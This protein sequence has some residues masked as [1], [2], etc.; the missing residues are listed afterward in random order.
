MLCCESVKTCLHT[1]FLLCHMYVPAWFLTVLPVFVWI[2]CSLQRVFNHRAVLTLVWLLNHLSPLTAPVALPYQPAFPSRGFVTAVKPCI[3]VLTHDVLPCPSP[4]PPPF[5]PFFCWKCT[6]PPLLLSSTGPLC[7]HNDV[8]ISIWC[9]GA[10]NGLFYLSLSST[11]GAGHWS[12]ASR[13]MAAQQAAFYSHD[14]ACGTEERR[15]EG[16]TLTAKDHKWHFVFMVMRKK[17][18]TIN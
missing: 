8:A 5:Y 7:R 15:G 10:D 2:V 16:S 13:L 14:T 9:C 17:N 12:N 3:K 18:S 11:K 4:P 6:P 1:H